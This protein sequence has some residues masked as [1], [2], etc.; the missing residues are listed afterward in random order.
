MNTQGVDVS[1]VLP[2]RDRHEHLQTWMR[3]VR[4]KFPP[5]TEVIVVE[6][7]RHR[8]FNRGLLLNVGFNESKGGRVIFHD[9]DLV[10]DDDLLCAYFGDWHGV[11]HFGCRFGRYNNSESYFGGVVGFPR[12]LF[13]G[14]SN[15]YFGWGGEDDSLYSRCSH[16]PIFRPEHGSY[17]DLEGL[18]TPR[19][20]LQTLAPEDKCMNKWELRSSDNPNQ[21]NHTVV[22]TVSERRY[23]FAMN[24]KWVQC[25]VY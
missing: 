3:A 24:C 5:T 11:T 15:R 25:I 18:Q 1:I 19:D 14:F 21:D 20:K 6:Q 13:P 4:Q 12:A 10:P 16:M 17:T 23:D 7:S 2:F 22:Q 8:A 9:C